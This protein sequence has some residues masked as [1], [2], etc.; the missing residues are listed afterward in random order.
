MRDTPLSTGKHLASARVLRRHKGYT[1]GPSISGKTVGYTLQE[2]TGGKK[3]GRQAQENLVK[4][5]K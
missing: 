4:K 3:G 5:G 1:G 2:L